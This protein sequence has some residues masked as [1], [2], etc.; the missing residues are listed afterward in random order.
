MLGWTVSIS[1]ARGIEGNLWAGAKARMGLFIDEKANERQR[2]A[3]QSIFADEAVTG[4]LVLHQYW[5]ISRRRVCP[6][7]IRNRGPSAHWQ[8]EFLDACA[9]VPRR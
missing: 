4:L 1:G 7:L 3:L 2:Q 6:D 9:D 5:R 8:A